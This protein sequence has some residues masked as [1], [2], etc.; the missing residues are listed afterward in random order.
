MKITSV[1]DF[2]R[3]PFPYQ[4]QGADLTGASLEEAGFYEANL[5]GANFQKA[6]LQGA[7]LQGAN[8]QGANLQGANLRGAALVGA[9][10]RNANLEGAVLFDALLEG[11]NLSGA[12]LPEFLVKLPPLGQSFIAWKKVWDCFILKLEIPAD[13]PRVSTFTGRKCRAKSAKVLKAF[14]V[15][16][17]PAEQTM[18]RSLRD[19]YFIYRVGET[20][21]VPDF[22]DDIRLECTQG[23]H[24][25]ETRKEAEEYVW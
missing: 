9:N 1:D 11:A 22:N 25:F 21:E 7:N 12:K 5:Q 14:R 17:K 18:F 16:G 2:K 13:S 20:V 3:L 19:Y 6:Y 15:C 4:L 23:I 24:F 10:L 8:L